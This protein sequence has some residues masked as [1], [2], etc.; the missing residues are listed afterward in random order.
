MLQTFRDKLKGWVTGLVV[1]LLCLGFGLWGVQSYLGSG[2]STQVIAR[3]NGKDITQR[4]LDTAYNR[5]RQRQTLILGR[6]IPLTTTVQHKLREELLK[7][8]IRSQVL[9]DAASD[10]GYTVTPRQMDTA[11]LQMPMFQVNGRF[12]PKRFQQ[13]LRQMLYTPETFS[14]ELK[15]TMLIGQAH[16]AFAQTAFSLPKEV[17]RMYRLIDQKRDFAYGLITRSRFRKKLNISQDD[18]KQYYKKHIAK[19]QSTEEIKISYIM[20]TPKDIKARLKIGKHQAKAYYESNSDQYTVKKNGKN[21]LQPFNLVKSRVM[22]ALRQRRLQTAFSETSDRLAELTYTQPDSLK[23]ASQTLGLPIKTSL[24]ITRKGT[25]TG[26][27]SNPKLLAAAFSTAV[28]QERNNS[29]PIQMDDDALLVLRVTAHKPARSQPLKKVKSQIV[30]RLKNQLAREKVKVF[31]EQL[32]ATIQA[33]RK[34]AE[35]AFKKVR[36]RWEKRPL[37][38]RSDSETDK[39]ILDAAFKVPIPTGGIQQPVFRG[40]VL[41]SGDY[42]IVGLQRVLKSSGRRS[43][44]VRKEMRATLD[45]NNGSLDYLL[46]VEGNMSRARISRP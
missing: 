35:S 19:F 22:K 41:P 36:L 25:N 37:A 32:L 34:T 10:E 27:T 2:K 15:K 1:V 38:T 43:K 13:L 9:A 26:I 17:R 31:G 7:A 33:D 11:I 46:Y 28:L 3:V 20:L 5:V 18:I 24:W 21:I 40:F 30:K 23:A 45:K 29:L 12:S 14:H 8:L 6:Q 39:D 4:Q 16:Y 44:K 42:L